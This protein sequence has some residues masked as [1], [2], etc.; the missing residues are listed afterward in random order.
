MRAV[1]LNAWDRTN[2]VIRRPVRSVGHV[3]KIYVPFPNDF[4]V[5]LRRLANVP[6]LDMVG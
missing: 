1:R 6:A 2:Q 4:I 3:T 5:T